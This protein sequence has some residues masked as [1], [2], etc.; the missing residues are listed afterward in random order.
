MRRRGVT[1][2]FLLCVLGL[3]AMFAW[4][5]RGR[6]GG[7]GGGSYGYENNPAPIPPDSNE[8]TEFIW[9]RLRYP[10]TFARF[11]PQPGFRARFLDDGLP[12]ERPPVPPGRAAPDAHPRPLDG[13]R[14]RPRHRRHLQLPLGLRGRSRP[15][16]TQRRAGE[17]AARVPAARRLPHGGRFSRDLRV[18]SLHA[19]HVEGVSRTGRWWTSTTRTPFS[20]CSTTWTSG[21]KFPGIARS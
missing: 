4:Q 8:K 5:R 14:G 21:S 16:G 3:S 1:L 12:Q 17:E 11:R 6:R 18:G 10:T 20:T 15:L 7:G 2:V 9:A 19:E 13:A